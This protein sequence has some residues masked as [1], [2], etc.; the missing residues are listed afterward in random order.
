VAEILN[1]A[2]RPCAHA[3]GQGSSGAPGGA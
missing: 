2:R 1:P 3:G